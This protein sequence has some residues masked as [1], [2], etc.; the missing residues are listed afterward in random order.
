MYS[1][2]NRQLTY[3]PCPE[4]A[5]CALGRTFTVS[6]AC[7]T[8]R[9]AMNSC[10]IAKASREEEDLARE[11]YFAGRDERQRKRQEDLDAVE[12]RRE[13]VI[14][15]QRGW[16]ER[17]MKGKGDSGPGGETMSTPQFSDRVGRSGRWESGQEQE[18][19]RTWR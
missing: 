2:L 10:M 11:E 14:R 1:L 3:A 15:M 12:R 5:D 17:T 8:Q 18:R 16:E 6:F 4:F 7:R 13:E 19:G 9:Q